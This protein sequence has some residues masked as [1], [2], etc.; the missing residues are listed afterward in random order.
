MGNSQPV[1]FVRLPLPQDQPV[2]LRIGGLRVS[3]AIERRG[4]PRGGQIVEAV[5]GLNLNLGR[6]QVL[7]IL[8]ESGCGKSSLAQSLVRMLPEN[9]RCEGAIVFDGVELLGLGESRL[10]EIR[11]KEIALIHQTP[12][13]SLN[14]VLRV[15]EQ[16]SQV[17]RTHLPVSSGEAKERALAMLNEVQLPDAARIYDRYPHQL[18]GG[19][20]QRVAIAQALACR[21]KLVVADEPTAALDA[22]LQLEI[23]QL[24]QDLNGKFG[25][26]I[27]LITHD[28]AVL[29]A[30][31]DR[32]AVMYAG[33]VVEEG[34]T[35][36]IFSSP[37][38]PYTRA[39]LRLMQGEKVHGRRAF[40]VISGTPP[41]PSNLPPGC[42]FEPRCRERMEICRGCAPAATTREGRLVTCFEYE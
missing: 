19:Q 36:Q 9:A 21:P 11:G 8:G 41:D 34:S 14:P 13:L 17:I 23:L 7:G 4:A 39:L 24:L 6:G 27:L 33:R 5:R 10:N 31:A 2:L 25:S 20:Q 26:A 37:L 18:S 40:E 1:G 3:Y 32:V 22:T 29:A 28:P 30:V 38:H 12:G 35:R 16:I 15:G 42:E